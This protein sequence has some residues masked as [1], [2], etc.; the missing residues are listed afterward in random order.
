MV[1]SKTIWKKLDLDYFAS[2]GTNFTVELANGRVEDSWKYLFGKIFDRVLKRWGDI[3]N[4]GSCLEFSFFSKS[5]KL[6]E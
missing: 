6:T 2:I 1:S 5:P 3:Y 4:C